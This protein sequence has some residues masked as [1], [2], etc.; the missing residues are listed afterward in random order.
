[1]S[2]ALAKV[3]KET[4]GSGKASAVVFL[5]K[6][7][8]GLMPHVARDDSDPLIDKAYDGD[9]RYPMATF[10]AVLLP[11]MEGN[12]A[13]VARECDRRM[14][15]E[16]AKFNQLDLERVAVIGLPCSQGVADTCGCDH[17]TPTD[18][19]LP[20]KAQPSEPGE[21]ILPETTPERLDFW[22]ESFGECI[23]CYGCRN[24]CP[25]CFCKEC[26]LEKEDLTGNDMFPPD[27]P[28]FHII[29]ALDMADRCID[30]GMCEN[31]CPAHIPLR[32][33]YRHMRNLVKEIFDYEPGMDVNQKS[34]FGELGDPDR[35]GGP[36]H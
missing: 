16:L 17:P 20:A 10:A 22:M 6:E 36:P 30:C 5:M 13:V 4:L 7:G 27:I 12:L 21:E 23:R 2:E 1:M 18:S 32:T 9:E 33:L 8:D 28:A 24:V 11:L 14:L 19:A 25:I 15:V 34:P 26:A 35:L 31:I 3:I 29:R